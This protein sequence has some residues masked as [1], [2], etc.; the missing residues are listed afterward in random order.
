[1]PF[2]DA[3]GDVTGLVLAG[4]ASRRFGEDKARYLVDGAS[5]IERV[6]RA[7]SEVVHPVRISIGGDTEPFQLEL[8]H[9]RDLTPDA[10]PL[11]G[12]QAGLRRGERRWLLVVACDLPFLTSDVLTSLLDARTSEADATVARTPE[13]ACIR[14]AP[15][16]I[17]ACCASYCPHPPG[18][19]DT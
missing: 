5:M 15:A 1:M 9:V 11:G 8:E 13:D 19:V 4:G 10:G 16:I 2:E 3:G 14:I 6:V 7:V 17:A 18:G 12:L